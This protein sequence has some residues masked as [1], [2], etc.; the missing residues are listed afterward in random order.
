MDQWI[1]LTSDPEILKIVTGIELEFMDE[2]VQNNILNQCSFN[3]KEIG[4]IDA[5]IRK[6]LDKRV[7]VESEYENEQFIS[8]IFLRPK[9]DGKYRLMCNLKYLN[10]Y[11][12]YHHFKM[13]SLF[14][15]LRMIT[16]GCY[17]ASIDL[18]DAY[19]CI[20]VSKNYQKYLKFYWN[21]KLYKYRA[22]PMVYV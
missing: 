11:I 15:V 20:P 6:L 5:E 13:D 4:A 8:P 18:K 19:Y 17:M 7:I 12:Q 1:K 22:C 9:K 14:S 3:E 16:P 21:S 2:P 10:Q